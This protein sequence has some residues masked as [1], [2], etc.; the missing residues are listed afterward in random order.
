MYLKL[1]N[2]NIINSEI[3]L[4]ILIENLIKDFKLIF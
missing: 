3:D 4:I 1:I 2:F